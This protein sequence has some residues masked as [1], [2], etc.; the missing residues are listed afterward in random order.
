MFLFQDEGS[1]DSNEQC[2]EL[3]N[4]SFGFDTQTLSVMDKI[5][6][7][8][9]K[10]KS[11]PLPIPGIS[12]IIPITSSAS[13]LPFANTKAKNVKCNETSKLV[14][15][16]YPNG[17]PSDPKTVNEVKAFDEKTS[18]E[19]TSVLSLVNVIEFEQRKSNKQ[20]PNVEM[21]IETSS[22]ETSKLTGE[23]PSTHDTSIQSTSQGCL[24]QQQ[25]EL[26]SWGLPNS[27]LDQYKKVGIT[28][29]FEWQA[30]CLRTG[31]VL[32]GGILI[33]YCYLKLNDML[34][35]VLHD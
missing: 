15:E 6:Q 5:E 24:T 25:C 3:F 17:K 27:V 33:V 9:A 11:E 29:M 30:Q 7:E 23:E 26:S 31:N 22:K 4:S 34:T 10:G 13:P 19:E 20:E 21:M 32:N 2:S 8:H 35:R 16:R 12:P 14:E 28:T 18:N 1:P